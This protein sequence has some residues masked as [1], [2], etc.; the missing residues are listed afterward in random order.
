MIASITYNGNRFELI[1]TKKVNH[2]GNAFTIIVG[3]NGT[4]KSRLLGKIASE[5]IERQNPRSSRKYFETDSLG[6][7]MTQY[8]KSPLNL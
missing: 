7:V 3:K 5:F 6:R 8:S 2:N 4:G 1:K